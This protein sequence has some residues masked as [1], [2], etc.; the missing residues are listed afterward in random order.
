[1]P[2]VRGNMVHWCYLI[3]HILVSCTHPIIPYPCFQGLSRSTSPA[4]PLSAL[5]ALNPAA[6]VAS[7]GAGVLAGLV[8]NHAPLPNL[9]GRTSVGPM[10]DT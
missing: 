4:L 9:V 10:R 6:L 5:P 1:M 7:G 3:Q 8:Q 2:V